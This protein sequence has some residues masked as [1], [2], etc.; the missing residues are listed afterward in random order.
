MFPF[1]FQLWIFL[2]KK[3]V[4]LVSAERQAII[5][6]LHFFRLFLIHN[7]LNKQIWR[8]AILSLIF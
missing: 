2:A 8:N 1:V 3:K 5:R 6:K 4:V 7:D